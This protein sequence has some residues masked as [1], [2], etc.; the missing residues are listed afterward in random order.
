M[1]STTPGRDT[2]P[3]MKR[4]ACT[5]LLVACGG[6]K[7]PTTTPTGPD[8]QVAAPPEAM[9]PPDPPKAVGH[10]NPDLVARTILFGN[11]ERAQVRLSPD[12]KHIS[13][14]AAKDGVL[15]VFVAPVDK[16][17]QA[18]AITNDTK[19][20]IRQ[21]FWAYD[22]KHVLYMQDE[23]GN[24]NFHIFRTTADGGDVTDLTPYKDTRA[25]V[26]GLSEKKPTTLVVGLN[27]RNPQLHDV[28]T[29]DLTTGKRQIQYQNDDGLVGFDTD[30]DL[31]LRTASKIEPDGSVKMFIRKAKK[32]EV[33]DTVP[34]EDSDTTGLSGF[35]G[36]NSKVYM[37]DSRGRDTGAMYSVDIA[38]KKKTLIA[39][40]AKADAG[41]ALSHPTKHTLQAISFDTG[42]TSWTVLDKSIQA[43]V[44]GLTKLAEGG[45]WGI[46]SRTL[47]DKTWL[48]ATASDVSAAKYYVW[49]RA[50]HT[51]KFLFAAQPKLP[52]EKLGHS[53]PVTIKSRD[54]LELPS[55]L[56]LPPDAD[57][58]HDGKADAPIPAILFVHGGPW[59][60]DHWGYSPLVQLMATR[61]YAVLQ[62]NY[63]GST[64]FGKNFI[65]ASDKQWGKK[66]HD[67]LIDAVEWLYNEKVAPKGKVCIVGG[68]YG[69]YAT[70][71]GL[72]MTPDA[73]ACGVDLVGPSNLKTLLASIPPYW[74]PLIA[75]FKKRVGD[76]DTD[77]GKAIIQA[78]S[79]L[80]Y[81][82]KI[83]KPLLIGQGANDPR[84]KQ[85]ES[86]QIV[87][88][89]KQHHLPVTYALFPDEGHGFARP[90]NNIAFFGVA[91][92]FLSAHIGG[93]YLPMTADELSAST[94]QIK[95][96][97]DGIPG[98]P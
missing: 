43:D 17:D 16:L 87:A 53:T 88:A 90:E 22:N 28:Y 36:S 50:K 9:R 95:E 83:S 84:V 98:L 89:M 55:Y 2:S 35:D 21:Y 34:Y 39:E 92:A 86:E 57:K 31:Q 85:A 48:V 91:E 77:E 93:Q 96:G 7:P 4:I 8:V 24:E 42:R 29:I 74:A 18:K 12:G 72:S 79:P 10:P 32:W 63:R 78:A 46:S 70:L 71:A 49:D 37:T 15:N 25:E 62:V 3:S 27:D 30:H 45:D 51:G 33:W 58:D 54:G 40:N 94:M 13:W 47:D 1:W 73:F 76:P 67:D 69:G 75:T 82:A 38:T 65:N 52:S 5:L 59:A 41:G 19:R 61:G 81:V 14:L 23:G 6:S 97:K 44:D 11:P 64:G 68:S 20:P 26:I 80:T 66:M 60:R 56:T